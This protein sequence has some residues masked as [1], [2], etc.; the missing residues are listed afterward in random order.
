[1]ETNVKCCVQLLKQYFF[2]STVT[3]DYPE[4][5]CSHIRAVFIYTEALASDCTLWGVVPD[6]TDM[7]IRYDM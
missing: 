5:P 7:S 2:L 3:G 1:V 4:L 6:G